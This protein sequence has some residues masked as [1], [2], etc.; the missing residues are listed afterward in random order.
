[1]NKELACRCWPAPDRVAA[2]AGREFPGTKIGLFVPV[3]R[4]QHRSRKPP[5]R[6]FLTKI[7]TRLAKT[8][9]LPAKNYKSTFT[10]LGPDDPEVQSAF[11]HV[12]ESMLG[13]AR[14]SWRAL[15]RVIHPPGRRWVSRSILN[16]DLPHIPLLVPGLHPALDGYKIAFLS[17]IHAGPY[18]G[19]EV[20]GSLFRRVS[21][22]KADLAVM[23]GDLVNYDADEAIEVADALR[24]LHA[25]D[26]V[27]FVPGNHDHYTKNLP[28][29]IKL[30]EKAGARTLLNDATSIKRSGEHLAI[31]GVDDG[32]A[33]R[34]DLARALAHARDTKNR[35]LLSHTPD[36]LPL[37]SRVSIDWML[38]G[39]THGGQL[40]AGRLKP[41]STHTKGRYVDGFYQTGRTL[42]F[43]GRGVGVVCVP[44]RT[45]CPPH[46][47]ILELRAAPAHRH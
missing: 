27:L 14:I 35:I 28:F 26:G 31:L 24:H 16:A 13:A 43:V 7:R 4:I 20:L 46:V 29:I 21:K 5:R 33:G 38:S 22:E 41:I 2:I 9:L 47:P 8:G 25:R 34:F 36:A 23:C 15:A 18:L 12:P 19:A 11:I 44:M 6:P 32:G 37:A 3:H 39:H 17:D 45:Y 10:P 30:L 1:M 40:R 42:A